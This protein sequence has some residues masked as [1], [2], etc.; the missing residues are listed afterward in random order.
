[1]LSSSQTRAECKSQRQQLGPRLPQGSRW[2]TAPLPHSTLRLPSSRWA[3]TGWSLFS[4][5][6]TWKDFSWVIPTRVP[7]VLQWWGAYYPSRK[8][9]SL[10]LETSAL[11]D[12]SQCPST[13]LRWRRS[14][15]ESFNLS[16]LI[17]SLKGL[18]NQDHHPRS[19]L[20]WPPGLT[21][22]PQR[23]HSWTKGFFSIPCLS[24]LV[25]EKSCRSPERMKE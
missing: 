5:T 19:S 23:A 1:M 21:A 22:I 16:P 20:V 4:Q 9:I 17:C 8:P 15:P 24:R 12:P 11:T 7:T 18:E 6:R 10:F 14:E 3:A 13:F 2:E 25:S